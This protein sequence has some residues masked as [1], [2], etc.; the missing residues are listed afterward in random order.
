MQSPWLAA[1]IVREYNM[2][3]NSFHFEDS[4]PLA[5]ESFNSYKDIDSGRLF[6]AQG[7]M[8]NPVK[9]GDNYQ[10][11]RLLLPAL[12]FAV[13]VVSTI[14][15]GAVQQGVD[16]FK[17][18]Y[19]LVDGIPFSASLLIILLT[20]EMGHF[21]AS[22]YHG[23]RATLPYFIPAPT[24][25]GTFGAFIKMKSPIMN[26]RA[27]VDIGAAGPLAGFVMSVIFTLIGLKLSHV[28]PA[29]S[30]KGIGLGTSFIF[31][32]LTYVVYGSL[33]DS[34][35]IV[36]H[37]VAFAGWIGFFVTSLNLL[38]IGQLDGGHITYAILGKS[39]RNVSRAV[40]FMLIFF[41]L[42]GWPGWFVWAMLVSVLGTG[43]PPVL[44]EYN[45][46]DR[47]RKIVGW[48]TLLVF[49]LTFMPVPFLLM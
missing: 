2:V 14:I 17:D 29:A 25:L 13:T 26:K 49:I 22:R 5:A 10:K 46:L 37:P 21:I 40:I 15:A 19:G 7:D 27:L 23:V 42:I 30:N 3:D 36:L 16:P 39:H 11:P 6:S 35:D 31:D 34:L 45:P 4:P 33:P 8:D 44:Y 24:F 32:A 38:P 20:H 47:R 41:G 48:L 43:H 1:G 18:P 12:L 9:F 28:V